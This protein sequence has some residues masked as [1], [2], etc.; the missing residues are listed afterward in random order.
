M[1]NKRG[2]TMIEMLIY[3]AIVGGILSS[4]VSFAISLSNSR[5]KTYA[6]QEVQANAREALNIV[7]QKIRSASGINANGSVFGLDPGY[8]SLVMPS[9]AVNPTIISLNH[10]NGVIEIKEGLSASTTIM[11]DEV[12]VAN[13]IFTN[14]TDGNRENVRINMTVEYDNPNNDPDFAYTQTLQTAVSV[15]Y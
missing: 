6:I 5:N 3:V 1:M 12:K 10:D 7:T 8:L 2:F 11:A 15:R 14:L 13:L 9:A 4:F